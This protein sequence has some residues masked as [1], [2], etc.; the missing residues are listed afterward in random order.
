MKNIFLVLGI[1]V[2]FYTYSQK[3][4]VKT[5][6]FAVKGNCDMCQTRIE[7]AADIKG[8]KVCKWDVDKKVATVTYDTTKTTLVKIQTSIA[9]K[10][11]DAGPIKG[12]DA[13]YSKLPGCCQYR[14]RK[15]EE[16]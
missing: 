6:T 3:G 9:A 10:G 15:H 8:V 16:K 7:N 13:A 14:D 12:D 2:S 11:Y 5:E 4:T 1:L